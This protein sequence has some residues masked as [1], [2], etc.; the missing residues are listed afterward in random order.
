LRNYLFSNCSLLHAECGL[1]P[2]VE[3]KSLQLGGRPVIQIG[4]SKKQVMAALGVA[5]FRSDEHASIFEMG[6]SHTWAYDRRPY[7][8][9]LRFSGDKLENLEFGNHWQPSDTPVGKV[10]AELAV[11]GVRLGM[12]AVA[13]AKLGKAPSKFQGPWVQAYGKG[14]TLVGF[15]PAE[16]GPAVTV[17]GGSLSRGKIVLA[18]RGDPLPKLLLALKCKAAG[19]GPLRHFR[20]DQNLHLSVRVDAKE[21]IEEFELGLR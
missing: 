7:Q 15:D 18:R 14:E 10:G 4:D 1:A 2:V 6:A 19:S 20:L 21:K 17:L 5:D 11:D 13:L 16:V 12:R 8:L 3:G 9:E